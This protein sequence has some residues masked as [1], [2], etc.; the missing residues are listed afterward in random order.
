MEVKLA[1][2]LVLVEKVCLANIVA[3]VTTL[4][5]QTPPGEEDPLP[6]PL[7]LT[8]VLA[9]P[10]KLQALYDPNAVTKREQRAILKVKMLLP[11]LTSNTYNVSISGKYRTQTATAVTTP[12]NLYR[13]NT[14][15]NYT[16]MKK[17]CEI[18]QNGTTAVS[19]TVEEQSGTDITETVR[20]QMMTNLENHLIWKKNIINCL[21]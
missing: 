14:F 16:L 15:D 12:K 2:Q 20:R 7:P 11:T 17:Q 3:K 18:T 10:K 1:R 6:P 21:E 13:M 4:P 9:L 5:P 19:V 8:T